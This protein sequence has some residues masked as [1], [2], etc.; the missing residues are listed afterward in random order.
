MYI[1]ID[2]I[3]QLQ[4]LLNDYLDIPNLSSESQLNSDFASSSDM[5]SYFSRRKQ[6]K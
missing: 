6:Q 5:S 2:F 1:C 3:F 4:L